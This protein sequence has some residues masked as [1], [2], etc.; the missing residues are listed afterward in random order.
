MSDP[1]KFN[2]SAFFKQQTPEVRAYLDLVAWKDVHQSLNP[3]GS[4]GGYRERNGVPGS[5]GLMPESAIADNGK[6]PTDELRY[7]VGRYQMKNVD[8]EHMRKAYDAKIDDFSPESQDRIAVAKMKYRG[9]MKELEEGDIRGAIKKGGV[10]WASLPGSPYGQVQKGYT[11]DIAVDYYKQRLAFH[12]ALDKGGLDKGGQTQTPAPEQPSNKSATTAKPSDPMADGVLEKGEKGKAVTELQKALDAAGM[13]DAKGNR[14][15]PDGDF[16]DRTKEAVANFQRSH[17]LKADG[18][19]GPDTFKALRENKQVLQPVE[20]SSP[21][22][23]IAKLQETKLQETKPQ[24]PKPQEPK[25]QEPAAPNVGTAKPQESATPSPMPTTSDKIGDLRMRM[26]YD[27]TYELTG[28]LPAGTFKNTQERERASMTIAGELAVAGKL[29]PQ[30][31]VLDKNGAGYA[32]V[33]QSKDPAVSGERPEPVNLSAAKQQPLDVGIRM[34]ADQS[35][36][37]AQP[38]PMLIA[39][40][41]TTKPQHANPVQSSTEIDKTQE[42]TRQK[43]A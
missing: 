31:I 40:A 37:L 2:A 36:T 35:K 38:E 6:L 21:N 24:E 22:V 25:P 27:Q 42:Q 1:S 39:Q 5:R 43:L 10:E 19:V 28:T 16:G 11:V 7:N 4:P 34:L 41:D 8:V 3:D 13:R 23:G 17:G 32:F 29:N 26:L 14:L 20:L 9:V 30:S 18:E 15:N 33:F 12:Q